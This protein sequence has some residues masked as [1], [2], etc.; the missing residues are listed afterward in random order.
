M[1]TYTHVAMIIYHVHCVLHSCLLL[2]LFQDN[3]PCNLDNKSSDIVPSTVSFTSQ[4]TRKSDHSTTRS[5][6]AGMYAC[7]VK[8]QLRI[9]LAILSFVAT[10][11]IVAND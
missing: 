11:I 5:S 4:S 10:Y 1:Y 2:L 7:Q 3:D 6:V 8:K 9:K